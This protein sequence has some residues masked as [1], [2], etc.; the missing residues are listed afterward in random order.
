MGSKEEGG[1]VCIGQASGS[2]SAAYKHYILR[3]HSQKLLSSPH[4][5]IEPILESLYRGKSIQKLPRP[6]PWILVVP[7]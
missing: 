6:R 1:G 5:N 3:E 2:R 7:L 4:H